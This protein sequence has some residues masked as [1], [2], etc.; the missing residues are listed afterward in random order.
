MKNKPFSQTLE[1]PGH[2]SLFINTLRS[3]PVVARNPQTCHFVAVTVYKYRASKSHPHCFFPCSSS[4]LYRILIGLHN[5]CRNF[6]SFQ[7][8][9]LSHCLP[10]PSTFS[11]SSVTQTRCSQRRLKWLRSFIHLPINCHLQ[12]WDVWNGLLSLPGRGNE[13][14]L[15]IVCI[16]EM[17][18][19]LGNEV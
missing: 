2:D 12:C 10:P 4:P 15:V 19:L 16:G 8:S 1:T 5:G 18:L 14:L 9:L 3:S 11:P 7:V 17:A 13:R 6:P